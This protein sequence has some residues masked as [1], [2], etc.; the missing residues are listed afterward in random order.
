VRKRFRPE[1]LNRLDEII[2]FHRLFRAQMDG[3]VSIQI[4]RLQRLLADRKITLDLDA[5]AKAWLAEAGYDPVYGAR[6][7]K[8]VI[9]RSLQDTLAEQLLEGL[10]KDGDAVHISA[11]KDGL[12]INERAKGTKVH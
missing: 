2:L 5:K 8:R 3:V 7:L 1:F 12:T 9:Q 6:P 11:N 10:I 4:A